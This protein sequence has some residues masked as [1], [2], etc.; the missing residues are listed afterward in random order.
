MTTTDN[1][2]ADLC[3]VAWLYRENVKLTSSLNIHTVNLKD[4]EKA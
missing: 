1:P 4:F 2:S 3:C